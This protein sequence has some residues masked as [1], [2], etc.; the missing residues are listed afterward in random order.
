MSENIDTT[1]RRVNIMLDEYTVNVLDELG[2]VFESSR[3]ELVRQL[4]HEA[5][6][7]LLTLAKKIQEVKLAEQSK[8][9]D[10]LKRLERVDA[11]LK[12]N[13]QKG[14]DLV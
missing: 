6:P 11:A 12:N 2:Q 8:R 3:S 1:P 14:L 13:L 4:I 7:S 9:I 10:R 5:A